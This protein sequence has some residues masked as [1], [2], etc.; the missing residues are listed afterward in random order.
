MNGI[1]RYDTDFFF[2]KVRSGVV[3]TLS[4]NILNKIIGMIST[5]IITRM[6]TTTDYG[7]LSYVL[8]IYSY[9][10]LISGL[11]LISGNIQFATENKGQGKA[12]SY[13]KYC[14]SMGLLVD[15]VI[16]TISMLLLSIFKLP[17]EGAKSY[18]LM[19]IPLLLLEYIIA[20]IQGILR[21]RNQIKE[22]AQLLNINSISIAIGTCGGAFF[23]VLGVIIGRYVASIITLIYAGFSSKEIVE[24]VR[25]AEGLDKKEKSALWNYSILVGASSAMNLLVHQLDVTLIAVMVKTAEDVGLYK[26]GTIIPNALEFIPSALVIAILP[27]IIYHKNEA[28]WIR[29]NIKKT[30]L[31]LLLLN[32]V[33][34]T[35]VISTAPLI[36]KVV[37]GEKYLSVLPIFRILTIGYFFSGTFRGLSV[38]L[39][40]AFRRVKFGLLVS[41]T[42]CITDII[43]NYLFIMKF[44][45]IG[46]A[47]A[48]LLA[49]I[50]SAGM[51]F[52]Y[53]SILIK[54]GKINALLQMDD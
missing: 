31:Y 10:T 18:I 45:V 44:G 48:T 47:Y 41:V 1:K 30:Y 37:S 17:I 5:M 7:I 25:L 15:I 4:A 20:I 2:S 32:A 14:L 12:Y 38:N 43:F 13:Y 28:E 11:G 50:V 39:L 23:G 51:S 46:A 22:Y 3:H 35:V 9:L 21:S 27:S 8:N 49:A 36:I 52:T 24:Y 26:V 53:V 29:E 6:F 19:Y 42:T 33:L 34:T 54:R 16:A 40:A